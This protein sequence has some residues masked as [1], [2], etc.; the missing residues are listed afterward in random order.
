LAWYQVPAAYYTVGEESISTRCKI[1]IFIFL[2]NF[3]VM[4]KILKIITRV[5]LGLGSGSGSSSK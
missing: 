5:K 3:N 1:K 2:E 4:S